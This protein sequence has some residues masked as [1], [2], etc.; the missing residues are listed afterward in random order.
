M[1]SA[2]DREEL[3][4]QALADFLDRRA[5][6]ETPTIDGFCRG[7]PDIAGELRPQLETLAA[8]DD[9]LAPP[10]DAAPMPDRLSGYKILGE[11]G[12]G[13]MGR[14]FL[15][16][17]ERLGRKVAIKTLSPRYAGHPVLRA[18]FM[19][20]ARAMAQVT[21]P[22]IAR[23]YALGPDREPPHFVM[24]YVEGAPL[25]TAAQPLTLRQKVE[26]LR[27][28]ATAVGVLNDHQVIHRDLKPGNILAGPDL[29]PKLLDFG[30]ALHLSA[31]ESRLTLTGEVMGT[32]E[33]FSPEQ[34]RADAPLDAR[35][36]VFS[37]G[38]VFYELL[39]GSLPFRAGNLAGQVRS[40]CHDDPVLPRRIGAGIPGDLQN[41]CMKALE[42]SPADRYASAGEMAAD[43][44]RFLAG[45]AVLAAPASYARL[46]TGKIAQHLRELDGWRR[47]R[48]LSDSEY[49]AL[50]KGYDRLVEREDAWIM[51]F[52]RLSLPQVSLYLG[53]W[54]LV[55]GAALIVL[56]RYAGLSG[57]PAVL[58][59]AAAAAPTAWIGIR[60]WKM[61]QRRVAIAYLLAF[62]LLLPIALLVAMGEYGIF[63]GFTQGR[64]NLELFSKFDTF[65]MTTNAQL[66]W[67]LLL[68]LPAYFALRRFTRASVFSLVLA[69]MAAL[70]CLACLLRMGMIGWIDSDPGRPYF[71]L[72]PCAALFFAVAALLESRRLASDSRYFYPVAVLFTWAALTGVVTFHDPYAEWLKRAAP[73]TRGQIE[74]L[75]IINAAIYFALQVIC[76]RFSSPQLRTV[77][78]TFRFVIPGHVMTSLLFLGLAASGRA[79]Q[80]RGEARL[81]EILLP[82][83]ACLFVFASIPK[84]M[85]NFFASGM[86]FL[87]IGLVRIQ[88]DLFRD[89]A[90]W[91]ISLLL[92]G[93]LL[94][95][96]AARYSPL[97]MALH[98]LFRL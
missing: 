84:Q 22:N 69:M 15:A 36:D 85:K 73:W 39:T 32:P 98:R 24:E 54:I 94:M 77:A 26:L 9:V 91:P 61:Q 51:E 62:C 76:E 12:S 6:A 38:V 56:F 1:P 65:K 29:E 53:A 23:I 58:V 89:R 18:R 87:A 63:N 64:R 2:P 4:A 21:H 48:I 57:A 30:L 25:N 50:R 93:L 16:M 83:V 27:K 78:K 28:V 44:E 82:A 79:P 43:L 72:L 80:S 81:F 8:L 5:R 14:V 90:W 46:M 11:I 68:S 31:H 92:A 52:R 34:A 74:Y 13:G 45:E 96:A 3:L 33:Y 71:Y 88:Q 10:P 41:I 42:K 60:S 17:D 47:D 59:A 19:H 95:V 40:I 67:S 86:F 37:L 49:D 75:F 55:V 97:K 35:S 70:W 20:E 66:W 7:Y